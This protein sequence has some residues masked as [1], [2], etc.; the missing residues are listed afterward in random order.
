[1]PAVPG[2]IYEGVVDLGYIAYVLEPGHAFRVDVS[3]SNYPRFNAN[4]N[5]GY[6]SSLFRLP[7]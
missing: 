4:D 6:V 5:N 3:S 2:E 1:M 7:Y